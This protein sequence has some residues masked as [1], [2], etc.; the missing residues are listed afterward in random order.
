[1]KIMQAWGFPLQLSQVILQCAKPEK[2]NTN[3]ELAGV[4]ALAKSLASEWGFPSG[5]KGIASTE[6]DDLLD[7]LEVSEKKLDQW[8]PEL[9]KYAEFALDTMKIP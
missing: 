6:R 3:R 2:N 7:L 5:L 8:E 9:K 1:V 4:V